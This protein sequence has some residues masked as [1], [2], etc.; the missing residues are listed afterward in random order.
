MS[1]EENIKIN[2]ENENNNNNSNSNSNNNKNN[3]NNNNNNSNSNSNN[4]EKNNATPLRAK[5]ATKI[6]VKKSEH[7]L[8]RFGLFHFYGF[9]S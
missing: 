2:N 1:N 4:N 6:V 8:F 9:E 5:E 7:F 3:K